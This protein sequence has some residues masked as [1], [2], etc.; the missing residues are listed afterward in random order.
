MDQICYPVRIKAE[1][2]LTGYS[3]AGCGSFFQF[4]WQAVNKLT[5]NINILF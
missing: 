5:E 3:K 1:R 2:R 4:N